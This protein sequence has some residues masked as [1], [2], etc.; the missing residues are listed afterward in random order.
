[1]KVLIFGASGVI[2]QHM[3][4]R[5]PSG[6]DARFFRSAPDSC[7]LSC[8]VTNHEAL[9]FALGYHRPDVV[10]NLAGESNTDTV[11]KNPS[12]TH[13]I[14]SLVPSWIAEWCKENCAR[15]I[16][17]SS[18]AVFAG[19]DAPYAAEPLKAGECFP[20]NAYGQQ[21]AEAEFRLEPF[22]DV[23]TIIRPTFVLGVR[24]MPGIGRANPV[25]QILAGQKKQVAD[26]WFSPLFAGDAA[27]GI[28]DEV[29]RKTEGHRIV[30]LG[31]QTTVS[32]HT[33]ADSLDCIVEPVSH[34]DFPGIAP[35][36]RDT[37]YAD[38]SV[39]FSTYKAGIRQLKKDWTARQTMNLEE[40]AREIALFLK[41]NEAE[42]IERLSRGFSQLHNEVNQDFRKA[43]VHKSDDE[44]LAWYR[45]T[46]A[47]IWE[48]SAYHCDPGFN[49]A[50]MCK[51]MVD[52]LT[53]E[54]GARKVLCLGDGIGDLTLAL[55]RAGFDAVYHDLEG[56]RTSEFALFRF[57]MHGAEGRS[58]MTNGWGPRFSD[59]YDAV[60]SFD[61]LEHVTDVPAWV[62]A[63]KGALKPGG[64]FFAQNAFA[65]GSG[66]NGSIPC[67]LERND[68]YE[69]DWT[70]LVA[71]LDL[72]QI[73]T[74]N[75]YR[76]A[77]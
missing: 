44:L 24:P 72:Q 41:M 63:I 10:V 71:S 30:H 31:N 43:G 11:Q 36:P 34:D 28:W 25:E 48:L 15:Y 56:S 5:V 65:C 50:G 45:A 21:K 66:P 4:L 60:I 73:E 76:R 9:T 1:M 70:P 18:Q 51:G 12:A 57:W 37:S 49:Y 33:V 16:H 40:R 58:E 77:A 69:K 67:H 39:H 62:A 61:F 54:P 19:E 17:I 75:W 68:R 2:G 8:D 3:M 74:S 20:V 64:L 23:C 52:R 53:V 27:R 47:Y 29:T 59:G 38:G 14:N 46:E 42:A 7:F 13:T 35:R 22:R 32:R 55:R 6:V 26:R